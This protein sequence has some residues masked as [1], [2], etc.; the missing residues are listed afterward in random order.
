MP[1]G[2]MTGVRGASLE[3]GPVLAGKPA[4]FGA[5]SHEAW[6]EAEPWGRRLPLARTVVERRQASAPAAEGRRKPALRGAH[7]TRWC[8]HFECVC[9]RSASFMCR[10]RVEKRFLP[11]SLLGLTRQSALGSFRPKSSK[12]VPETLIIKA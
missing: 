8:G 5:A 3:L 9:R 11:S 7:R 6:P 12:I 1:A 10:K 2:T 4:A